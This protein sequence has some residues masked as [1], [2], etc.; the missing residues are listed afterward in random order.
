MKST[1]V[2]YVR[3]MVLRAP[4]G[5]HRRLRNRRRSFNGRM[6]E[7]LE[8][9]V[10]LHAN[11]VE[12]AEHI[13]VFG[14][15][16]LATGVITGGLVPDSSMTDATKPGA[17]GLW[18]DPSIW[19]N[20]VPTNFA[21]VLITAGT[22]VTINSDVSN[23]NQV[24]IH[25]LRVDGTLRFN[26]TLPSAA[27]G[28]PVQGFMTEKLLVDT[29]IVE[30]AWTRHSSDGSTTAVPGG[31]L[32]IGDPGT[33]M[34]PAVPVDP[35]IQVDIE[36]AD[37]GPVNSVAPAAWSNY[38]TSN[39]AW[40]PGQF[41]RGLISHGTV[42]IAG[43]EVQSYLGVDP[44]LNAPL[45]KGTTTIV[46]SSPPTGMAGRRPARHHGHHCA[47]QRRGQPGRECDNRLDRSHEGCQGKPHG[48]LDHHVQRQR[49]LDFRA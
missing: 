18:T 22:T 20:G 17:S 7:V 43:S 49:E 47:Q 23:G 40:D 14:S 10:L 12:D 15:H 33:L 13:A 36:F 21:N 41:S 19:T 31:T 5:H 26:P 30:S 11:A 46:L 35:H 4:A 32:D 1:L 16:N 39:A 34:R 24:A 28:Q 25:A 3:S 45:A 48:H 37:D 9:R 8:D 27:T 2:D 6:V 42:Y 29:I 44:T 38:T